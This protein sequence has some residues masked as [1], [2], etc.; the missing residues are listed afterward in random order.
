MVDL[1]MSIFEFLTKFLII[2][3]PRHPWV[4]IRSDLKPLETDISDSSYCVKVCSSW[5]FLQFGDSVWK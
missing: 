2:W 3:Q 4:Y 5:Y 1:A